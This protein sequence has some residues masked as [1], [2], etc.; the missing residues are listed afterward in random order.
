M[1]IRL[2]PKSAGLLPYFWLVYLGTTLFQPFVDPTW[3]RL[4]SL[5][6]AIFW[7]G[8]L[9]L[10]FQSYWLRGRPLLRNIVALCALGFVF[11][12]I[13]PNCSVS[14]IYA[15]AFAVR[16]EGFAR[17]RATV[18]YVG[19][20]CLLS[21]GYFFFVQNIP[22]VFLLAWAPAVVFTFVIG[23][24]NILEAEKQQANALIKLAQ[25]DVERLARMAERERIARDLH[26]LLGHT[27]TLITLKA[28]LAQKLYQANS[29]QTLGE[30]TAI[31]QISREALEGV[32]EAVTGYRESGLA[33]ELSRARLMCE[34]AGLLLTE[35]IAEL[36]KKQELD[37]TSENILAVAI[38]EAVTNSVK[39]SNATQIEIA[40][41]A[42][43]SRYQLNVSDNGSN[44]ARPRFG[45]GL[46]AM[47][48]RV[49]SLGGSLD[50]LFLKT[51]TELRLSIPMKAV[52]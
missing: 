8:F 44:D 37:A 9:L 31:E 16:V 14:F 18:T 28:E 20:S 33:L 50:V 45:N 29:P 38:R 51:K 12:H 23:F 19:T 1:N 15:A 49:A 24:A 39:H 40:L 13:N 26:D 22:S 25:E 6:L 11:S 47:Q 34:T 52:L 17:A 27:L 30:L 21:L 2:L 10:Y 42:D 3:S 4:D 43:D 35:D 48:E 7:L 32:R 41:L 36:G 46:N 5:A